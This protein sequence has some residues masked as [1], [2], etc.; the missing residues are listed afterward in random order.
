MDTIVDTIARHNAIFPPNLHQTL[1]AEGCRVASRFITPHSISI[2]FEFITGSRTWALGVRVHP[3]AGLLTALYG[4][5]KSSILT[6][7]IHQIFR[8]GYGV[9]ASSGYGLLFSPLTRSN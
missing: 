4:E 2:F 8:V 7:S 6:P 5:R 1:S 9:G 3:A